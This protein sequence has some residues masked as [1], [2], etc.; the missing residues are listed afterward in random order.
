MDHDRISWVSGLLVGMAICLCSG[1]KGSKAGEKEPESAR[2]AGQPVIEAWET[3]AFD[4]RLIALAGE[5]D[6]HNR[7]LASVKVGIRVNDERWQSCSGVV[8]GPQVVLTAGHCVC[9]RYLARPHE[10]GRLKVIDP[11][12]CAQTARV[13]TLRYKPEDKTARSPGAE[14]IR[15]TGSVHPHPE[16]KIVLDEQGQVVS[17]HADLA[18]VRV[19]SPLE[20]EIAVFPLADTPV[21]PG[22]TIVIVGCGYDETEQAHGSDRRFSENK[23][24]R[25]LDADGERVLVEQP[26]KHHYRSDSGGPCIR[27]GSG[28]PVLVGISSRYLGTGATFTSTY[29]YRDWI[30]E[31]ARAAE[32]P[33]RT[34][35]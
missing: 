32:S 22:E 33:R 26:G 2:D 29:G 5:I 20:D 1:C 35:P 7:Y 18:V 19:R 12:V 34:G 11:G 17:S 14:S 30:R 4:M 24:L 31:Q 6:I 16:L 10:G 15:Y 13:E 27:Q 8:I 25:F 3:L 9:S 21:Q 23:V 28:G